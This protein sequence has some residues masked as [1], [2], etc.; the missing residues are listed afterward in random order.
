MGKFFGF[1]RVH[2]EVS[3][4][5]SLLEHTRI[6]EEIP[7]GLFVA[8]AQVLAYIYQVDQYAKGQ[9]A[10]PER[11]PAMPIPQDLRVDANNT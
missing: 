2:D 9:G 8:V 3:I 5:D 6:D 10:K 7:E 11:R 4:I 1:T